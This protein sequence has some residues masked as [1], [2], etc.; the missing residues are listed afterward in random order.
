MLVILI[1]KYM[2]EKSVP[3]IPKSSLLVTKKRQDV[4]V[5][6]IILYKK[7]LKTFHAIAWKKFWNI[8]MI[9]SGS[10]NSTIANNN[11]WSEI[12]NYCV[13]EK[14]LHKEVSLIF[15][16][17]L[18]EKNEYYDILV[19]MDNSASRRNKIF[20]RR[21]YVP[22]EWKSSVPGLWSRID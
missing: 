11:S 13:R 6:N 2:V 14:T 17:Y 10:M 22:R 5:C 12:L 8:L 15:F 18:F 1:K 9:L 7:T 21:A 3:E 20:L 4:C 19:V 16:E